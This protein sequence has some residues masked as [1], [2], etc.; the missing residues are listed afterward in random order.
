MS[1][2]TV[3]HGFNV[4]LE[5][6]GVV[7]LLKSV[8]TNPTIMQAINL[9]LTLE[10]SFFLRSG[11]FCEILWKVLYNPKVLQSL[12]FSEAKKIIEKFSSQTSTSC[13]NAAI[14]MFCLLNDNAP[15]LYDFIDSRKQ[16]RQAKQKSM[17]KLTQTISRIEHTLPENSSTIVLVDIV[18]R[19]SKSAVQ[20]FAHSFALLISREIGKEMTYQLFQAFSDEYTLQS[21]I[22]PDTAN[23]QHCVYRGVM[24]K[25]TLNNLLKDVTTIAQ[26][27][28]WNAAVSAAYLRLTGVKLPI[29]DGRPMGQ[30]T[31]YFCESDAVNICDR[32]QKFSQLTFPFI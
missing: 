20:D 7:E 4:V 18:D 8:I 11:K 2:P 14:L 28:K 5:E 27:T 15:V 1:F 25:Q 12:G 6:N 10:R 17:P 26:A 32:L 3:G 30:Q 24:Q 31:F 13:R 9:R 22:D 23:I 16:A 21:F 19:E 29:A